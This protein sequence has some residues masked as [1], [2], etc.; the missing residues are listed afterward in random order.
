[1]EREVYDRMA[2]LES[3]HWWFVARREVLT[4]VI[5]QARL[6]QD[7]R[8][9][10]AGCGTG[11]NLGMLRR[12]GRVDAFEP[13][14]GARGY[15][16]T[17]HGV[18]PAEGALPDDVPFPDHAFDLVVA[19]DVIEHVDR[20]RESL[21]RLAR[22]VRP[23]GHLLVTVPAYAFLWS[24]HDERHHHKRRYTKPQLAAELEGAGAR[25]RLC[26]YFNTLLFPAIAGVRVAK[27]LARLDSSDDAMPSART[28]RL[29]RHVFAAERA[30]VGRFPLP[31]GVSIVAL[32]QVG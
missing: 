18:S 21:Q 14:A 28:N 25:I 1:M 27:N 32:A 2:V 8:L 11:G 23:G 9:L 5:E 15:V 17:T 4:S 13:D 29:L 16:R 7:A 12:F 6:P 24:R 22:C 20:P 19:L 3:V 30:L 10:E 26:T 31:F